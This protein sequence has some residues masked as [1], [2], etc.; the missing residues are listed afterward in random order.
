MSDERSLAVRLG[1]LYLTRLVHG[2]S[3]PSEVAMDHDSSRQFSFDALVLTCL[4]CRRNQ[5]KFCS[6]TDCLRGSGGRAR[7]LCQK[8][9][10][11]N[12]LSPEARRVVT[13]SAG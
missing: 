10:H 5:A 11:S 13:S 12:A 1:M 6:P 2:W 7:D 8:C 4:F 3:A 9:R